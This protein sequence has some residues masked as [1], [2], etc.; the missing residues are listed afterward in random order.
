MQNKLEMIRIFCVAA[1]S[2]NFKEA[3]TQLGIRLKIQLAHRWLD[4]Q[5]LIAW[6]VATA[7]L[8]RLWR[9][10]WGQRRTLC[11]PPMGDETQ[12][13]ELEFDECARSLEQFQPTKQPSWPQVF[14]NES[15]SVFRHSSLQI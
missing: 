12:K 5:N 8:G 4:A 7:D 10:E 2:R 14:R 15:P 11:L 1:E 3:A 13:N 6:R 9:Q